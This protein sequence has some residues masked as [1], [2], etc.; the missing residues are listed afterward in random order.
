MAISGHNKMVPAF[1]STRSSI[2]I[3]RIAM[4]AI[5]IGSLAGGALSDRL[6]RIYGLRIGRCG[7]AGIA[8]SL[9]RIAAGH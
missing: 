9:L 8:L 7:L 4:K 2:A 1:A 3:A 5:T 6:T